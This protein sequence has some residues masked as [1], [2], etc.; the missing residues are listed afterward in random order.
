[1]YIF[2]SRF[3]KRRSNFLKNKRQL[4]LDLFG[5]DS[6]KANTECFNS[7]LPILVVFTLFVVNLAIDF[8]D[9]PFFRAEKINDKCADGYLPPESSAS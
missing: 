4:V 5:S 7:L 6:Y 9:K 1:M 2:S 8:H 3:T